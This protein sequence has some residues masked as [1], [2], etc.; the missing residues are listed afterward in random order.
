LYELI[1][2]FKER[3]RDCFLS[4]LSIA[5]M[6]QTVKRSTIAIVVQCIERE[7]ALPFPFFAK[8]SIVP[9]L[10]FPL[11]RQVFPEATALPAAASLTKIL[12]KQEEG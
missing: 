7:K 1:Y 3:I 5:V 12:G 8:L 10:L 9:P 6:I 2:K 4:I 11:F